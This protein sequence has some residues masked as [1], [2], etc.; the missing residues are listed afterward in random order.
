MAALTLSE[1]KT[2][3][4]ITRPES[5]AELTDFIDRAEAAIAA[6]CGPLVQVA[7]SARVR[8]YGRSLAPK[9][10]PILSLTS[11]TPVGGTALTVSALHAPENG[12]RGPSTIEYVD[13]RWFSG[14]WYDVVYM[15]GHGAT[16]A[17]VPEDLRLAALELTRHLWETQRGGTGSGRPGTA[18][19][20]VTANTIPGAAYLF[21][22]RIE[23]LMAPYEQ[24]WL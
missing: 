2:H 13:G 5:D 17:D 3:L 21:P 14:R 6:K 20:D 10:A 11:V 4:N 12:L 9:V 23:Q 8:G 22:F 19:S 7:V 1:A 18:L 16:A 24:A 15:A